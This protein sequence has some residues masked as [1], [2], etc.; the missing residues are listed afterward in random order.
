M[1]DPFGRLRS[2]HLLIAFAGG[3]WRAPVIAEAIEVINP[4]TEL[5]GCG[6]CP[7]QQGGC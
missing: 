7:W 2:A 6:K 3:V 4:A 1:I 5:A